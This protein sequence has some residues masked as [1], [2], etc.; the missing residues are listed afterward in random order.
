MLIYPE[1]IN[2]SNCLKTFSHTVR[3]EHKMKDVCEQEN[4]RASKNRIE[5]V[6]FKF[7]TMKT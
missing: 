1:Q 4:I 3:L 2:K 6:P 7:Y 5:T